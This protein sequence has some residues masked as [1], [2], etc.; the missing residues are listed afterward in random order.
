MKFTDW[1]IQAVLLL[2]LNVIGIFSPQVAQRAKRMLFLTSFATTLAREGIIK[3]SVLETLNVDLK[4]AKNSKCLLLGEELSRNMWRHKSLGGKE[5]G[6]GIGLKRYLSIEDGWDSNR[7]FLSLDEI[8]TLG[9]KVIFATPKWIQYNSEE[10]RD[11]VTDFFVLNPIIS[12]P[13]VA[14]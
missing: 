6:E 9:D 8:R 4:L 10:M 14:A 7:N 12:K 5:L 11:D 2:H 3:R 1:I 13:R